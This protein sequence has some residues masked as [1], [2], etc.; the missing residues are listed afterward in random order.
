MNICVVTDGYP[1]KGRNEFV[2]VEQLCNQFSFIGNDISIVAPVSLTKRLLRRL[3]KLPFIETKVV[4]NAIQTIISPQF[5]SLGNVGKNFKV[6]RESRKRAIVK[7]FKSMSILPDVIYCHFWHNGYDVYDIAKEMDIPII[8]ASGE[9][10]IEQ[11]C[12]TQKEKSFSN[13]VKGVICVSTKNKDES[14]KLGLTTGNN[15]IIIPNAVDSSLFHKMDKDICRKKLGIEEED[16]VIA[17]VGGFIERKGPNRVSAAIS[18]LNNKRIKSIFIGTNRDG[19]IYNPDCEGIIHRGPLDHDNIPLYLNAA[20]VF[21]LPT[22]HEGCCNAIIEAMS[23][24]LPVISSNLPFNLD[25]LDDSNSILVD[26][27][28][29]D[30]ISDAINKI[31]QDKDLREEMAKNSLIKAK[32]LTLDKRADRIIEFISNCLENDKR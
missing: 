27:L 31:Y 18:K 12:N 29:I 23:C 28:N 14:I 16:F 20:D 13:Y 9:A 24:G 1:R 21:V 6:V 8:V 26:P 17:F 22:L 32:N 10:Q 30:E 11:K 19:E 4:K 15:C 25:I 5:I 7:A 2:F 3:P